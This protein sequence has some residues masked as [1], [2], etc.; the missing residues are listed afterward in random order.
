MMEYKYTLLIDLETYLLTY[1]LYSIHPH[2]QTPTLKK[3][4]VVLGRVYQNIGPDGTEITNIAELQSGL[5][6][7]GLFPLVGRVGDSVARLRV[8]AC[9]PGGGGGLMFVVWICH[10]N[11]KF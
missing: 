1:P 4:P 11:P 3:T 9:V 6:Q 2:T 5:S 8:S 7:L 10:R